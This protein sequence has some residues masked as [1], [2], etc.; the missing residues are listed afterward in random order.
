MSFLPT[1]THSPSHQIVHVSSDNEKLKKHLYSATW[2]V[3]SDSRA[4]LVQLSLPFFDSLATHLELFVD[5]GLSAIS[6]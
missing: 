2:S 5:T 1:T 4:S 6:N 3:L